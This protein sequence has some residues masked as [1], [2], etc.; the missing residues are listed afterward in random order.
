MKKTALAC[1]VIG[2]VLHLDATPALAQLGSVTRALGKAQSAKEKVDKAKGL[3]I[4]DADERKI[5]EQISAALIDRFGVY[6]DAGVT[7]YVSLVG[8]VLA[9]ASSR[10]N[11]SWEFIVLDTDGVNAYA[12]PG[13]LVHITRGA[14]GLIK[15]EAELA[16]V[17]GHEIT[18]VT[19]KHTVRAIQQSSV[20]SLGTE[21]VADK[22]GGLGGEAIRRLGDAGFDALFNGTFSRDDEMESDKVG[23]ALANTLGYSPSGMG[24]VLNKI[25]ERNKDQKERNGWFASHPQIKERVAAMDKRIRDDKLNQ[26]AI[27]APRYAKTITFDVKA[28][29]LVATI[30]PG[31]RG[32]AGGSEPAKDDT[33]AKKDEKKAE[34]AKKGGIFGTGLLSKGS[35]S[36]NTGTVASAG[37]RGGVPD[38]DAVGGSN[39]NKIRVTIPAAELEAFKQGIA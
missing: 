26:T 15:N 38:R 6:Q 11:L 25:A 27:V 34:P 19:V 17:L 1:V 35:Q 39:R 29:A 5:G 4:T 33:S 10:P 28:A 12:A 3:I 7:K 8:T 20:T 2:L 37:S 21:I 30:A 16:G 32:L 9:R 13:G 31:E 22:A 24:A 23:I 14:L 36:Q 18:H